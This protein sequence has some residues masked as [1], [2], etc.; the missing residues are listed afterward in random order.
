MDAMA[1][2]ANRSCSIARSLSVLGQKWNFLL[3]REAFFGRTRYAEFQRIGIPNA[4]LV[5]RLT[6][7][8]DAGLLARSSYRE[9]GERTRD[10]YRLTEAGRDVMPL[11]AALSAWGDEHL[12]LEAGPS[13]SYTRAGDG[14][15]LHLAFVD[16]DGVIVD[17]DAVAVA[18]GAE[19][20]PLPGS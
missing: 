1:L 7:L 12:P 17:R 5:D 4:T 14:R 6:S 18:R 2:P 9:D 11:L 10:E 3:L 8:V 15:R 16:D 13:V 20:G 19:V